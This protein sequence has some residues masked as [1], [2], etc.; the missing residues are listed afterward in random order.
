MDFR[1]T[2]KVIAILAIIGGVLNIIVGGLA[3]IGGG[4]ATA[5]SQN[6]EIMAELNNDA[7]FADAMS[8]FSNAAGTEV[9]AQAATAGVGVIVIVAGII[10]LVLGIIQIIQGKSGLNAAKG[11][12][13]EKAFKWGIVVLVIGVINAI[14]GMSGGKGSIVGYI[15]NLA[16]TALFIYCAKSIRDEEAGGASTDITE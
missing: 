1:K 10:S 11:L 7:E 2:I 12:G 5:V 8:Q 15:V 14:V 3:L 16:I 9:D 13:A 4:A 6:E